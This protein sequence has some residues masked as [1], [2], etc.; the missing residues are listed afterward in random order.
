VGPAEP[1]YV[2]LEENSEEIASGDMTTKDGEH[3][4][5]MFSPDSV[6]VGTVKFSVISVIEDSSQVKKIS[7]EKSLSSDH[8]CPKC[9]YMEKVFESTTNQL[10]ALEE[11]KETLN[12]IKELIKDYYSVDRIRYAPKYIPEVLRVLGC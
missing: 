2:T 12:D 10:M 7:V 9:S 3:F 11:H 4:F 1:I 5:S 6:E 8:D